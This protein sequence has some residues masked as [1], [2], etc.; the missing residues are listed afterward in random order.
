MKRVQAPK[1]RPIW[2]KLKAVGHCEIVALPQHHATIIRMV[3]RTRDKD[4]KF[5][6]NLAEEHLY[7]KISARKEGNKISFTLTYRSR[8]DGL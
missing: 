6:L 1:Y 8:L 2:D 4:L 5:R 3:G 7:H